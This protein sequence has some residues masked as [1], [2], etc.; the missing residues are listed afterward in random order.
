V[1]NSALNPSENEKL[2]YK[3]VIQFLI[4]SQ[5]SNKLL[6]PHLLQIGKRLRNGASIGQLT[7]ELQSI[8]KTLTHISKQSKPDIEITKVDEG[9][10]ERNDYLLKRI[11]ELLTDIGV[12]QR[13]QKQANALKR[14]AK[15]ELTSESYKNVVD[16]GIA[17]LLEIRAYS[18]TEQQ[19]LDSFLISMTKELSNIERQVK[20]AGQANRLSIE[21][22]EN[23]NTT[24]NNQLGRMKDVNDSAQELVVLKSQTGVH[25]ERLMQQLIEH[26]QKED[27][28]QWQAQEQIELMAQKLKDLE[29]ETANLRS[30][31]QIEHDKAMCDFLTGLPNRLAYNARAE[32][33][34]NRWRRYKTPLSL[35]IFDI[36]RFKRI[37]DTYGHKAGDKTLALIGQLLSSHCRETDFAARYGGE[38]FVIL[39]PSTDANQALEMA[40]NI[41]HIILNSGFNFNGE[42]VNLSVSCGISEFNN[43]DQLDDV[44][45]RADQA[46]YQCKQAG[47][48][49]CAVYKDP[50]SLE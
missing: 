39:M 11:D 25:L 6:E 32:V 34:V 4:F 29:A 2:L 20:I 49:R 30:K 48:N 10:D 21:N 27:E 23:L 9:H 50:N 31:L 46:L 33:E 22:R 37:N 44:F 40:E 7:P 26:K 38:E 41:R 42:D 19:G 3:I 14:S 15:S 35:A 45:V 36:D 47:R 5:G 12:S 8:S 13:F 24:M 17:L 18:E 16:A 1:D 28:R 43:D